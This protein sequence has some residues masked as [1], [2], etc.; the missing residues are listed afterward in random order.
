MEDK[1]QGTEAPVAGTAPRNEPAPPQGAVRVMEI[2][3][4]GDPAVIARE[5]LQAKMEGIPV[6]K[7]GA[8]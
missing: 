5:E 6:V 2:D 4:A 8:H 3:Y 1:E 7:K